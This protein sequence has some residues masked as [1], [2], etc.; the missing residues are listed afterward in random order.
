MDT[1]AISFSNNYAMKSDFDNMPEDDFTIEFWA[2]TT[3]LEGDTNEGEEFS[4]F[5]SF[6]SI[7]PG[8]GIVGN[9]G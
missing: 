2:R 9:D 5:F 4:E 7:S 3:A 8:D 6:A 1:R